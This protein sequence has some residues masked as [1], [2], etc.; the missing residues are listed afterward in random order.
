M[1]IITKIIFLSFLLNK[2]NQIIYLV[3]FLLYNTIEVT[4][5]QKKGIL[6]TKKG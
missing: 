3:N 6:W 5:E 2:K 1:A 4:K